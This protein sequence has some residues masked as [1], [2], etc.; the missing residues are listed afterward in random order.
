MLQGLLLCTVITRPYYQVMRQGAGCRHGKTRLDTLLA[1][2]RIAEQYTG[3][4]SLM[5]DRQWLLLTATATENSQWQL[6]YAN[7]KPV[8]HVCAGSCRGEADRRPSHHGI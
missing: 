3:P 6:W 5:A 1:R 7:A 2:R 4:S 8:R